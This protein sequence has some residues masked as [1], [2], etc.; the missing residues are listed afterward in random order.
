MISLIL[1]L[2]HVHKMESE[3]AQDLIP[4]KRKPTLQTVGHV[5]MQNTLFRKLLLL[6]RL[7][8][9]GLMCP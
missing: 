2:L 9:A 1:S 7:W 6:E 3:T 4:V 8:S 5:S